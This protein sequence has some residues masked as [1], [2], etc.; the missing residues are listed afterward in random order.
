MVIILTHA[1]NDHT[2]NLI[3]YIQ[4]R[5]K[6]VLIPHGSLSVM[7]IA[8]KDRTGFLPVVKAGMDINK[9]EQT[10]LSQIDYLDSLFKQADQLI[11]QIEKI[12]EQKK[13]LRKKN[14]AENK[15]IIESIGKEIE[16]IES[17]IETC[18]TKIHED[19]HVSKMLAGR[20]YLHPEE[21]RE[22]IWNRSSKEKDIISAL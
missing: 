9:W 17:Q 14:S 16:A 3:Y 18:Y 15:K 6:E 8:L 10:M 7:R 1:H 12:H 19:P 20:H 2:G 5:I 22:I 11:Q 21:Y 4:E 13:G